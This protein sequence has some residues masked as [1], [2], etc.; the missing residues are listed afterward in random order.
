MHLPS[1]IQ[2]IEQLLFTQD[3][4]I[5]PNF[6]G[7]VV[8]Q[9]GYTYDAERAKIH[10]K[11]RWIAFNERLRADD[12]TLAIQLAK[13][14]KWTQKKAFEHVLAFSAE[15]KSIIL[16]NGT[17]EFGK[18]G[19]FT[20]TQEQK[21][22]FTPNSHLNFDLSQYGLFEVGTLG[23]TKPKL[24]E[25]PIPQSV[26]D[27]P[28]I[29]QAEYEEENT[30]KTFSSRFYAYVL[31][32]FIVGGLGAYILT[33]PNSKFVNSSFS[34]L[35]IKIKK[36]KLVAKTI[37]TPT[38]DT[39]SNNPAEK[40]DVP[41]DSLLETRS[42]LATEG[43]FLVAASFKTQE[44]AEKG[45]AE[46]VSRGFDSVEILPKKEGEQYFRVSVGKV[47]SMDEGYQA[48]ASLKK[49]KKVDIWVYQINHS[50]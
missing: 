49:S 4:V 17:M 43:I 33:E 47:A 12:G 6:G 45:L 30:R 46:F 20:L 21:I 40:A 3:C 36:E 24:I 8:N 50:L 42:K 9:Q 26:E 15:I 41:V 16:A 13:D 23:K 31:T 14:F 25:N 44:K 19:Q 35:T 5:I 1:I 7:F 10:P 2:S 37:V 39:K 38:A 22:S 32:A 48:A 27:L 18:I 34:P 29:S 11:K 28:A